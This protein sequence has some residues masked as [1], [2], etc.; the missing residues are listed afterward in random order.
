MGKIAFVFPGQG[1]QHPGMGRELYESSPAAKSVL[2]LCEGLRPG[3]LDQCFS[4]AMEVLTETCN[5]QPCM[6]AVELAAAAALEAS[7]IHADVTAGFSLGEIAALACSG[8]ASIEDA[9]T[10]VCQ[11]GRLMQQAAEQADTAM[12]AVLKLTDSQVEDLCKQ[13]EQVY[14]VNYNCPGQIT[15][16]GHSE[17]L[18][19]FLA[20]V[21]AVGGRGVPLKV[22]G[23]FHSPFMDPAAEGLVR[24]LEKMDFKTPCIPLY[25]NYTGLPCEDGCLKANL[26]LQVAHP[27]RWQRSVE[28]MLA[29]GVDTFL[30][31]GPGKTLCGLI[32]RIDPS[33]RTFAVETAEDLV[34]TIQE[35]TAC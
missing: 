2:D 14:A 20:D 13:Y 16:A 21:K 11:R 17:A 31:V 26:A 19:H 3:T 32:G 34:R 8:A 28:H 29:Q 15:V 5:T 33:A 27:V 24:V 22:R 35:V 23:G 10:L 1:A 30:E 9:F 18:K 6:L 7:G 25:S 4:G 12:A